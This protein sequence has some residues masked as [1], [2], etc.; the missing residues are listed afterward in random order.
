MDRECAPVWFPSR[1][2]EQREAKRR[3]VFYSYM[4]LWLFAS[5]LMVLLVIFMVDAPSL[6]DFRLPLPS[7]FYSNQ[8]ANASRE[9]A[10]KVFDN[11]GW[12]RVLERCAG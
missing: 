11:A 9:D 8:Q 10:L 4:N 1:A 12:S 3:P 7:S 2:A 5:V 6:H